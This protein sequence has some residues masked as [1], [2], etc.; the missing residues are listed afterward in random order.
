MAQSVYLFLGKTC[1]GGAAADSQESSRKKQKK[2]KR[3]TNEKEEEED[4]ANKEANLC[5]VEKSLRL[6]LEYGWRAAILNKPRRWS[7]KG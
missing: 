4:Q 5:K 3:Q 2:K 7:G 1:E 6:S